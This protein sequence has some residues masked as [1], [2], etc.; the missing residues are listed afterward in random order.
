MASL[1]WPW[2][3]RSSGGGSPRL[4]SEWGPAGKRGDSLSSRLCGQQAVGLGLG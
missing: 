1:V 2:H 4:S 3:G